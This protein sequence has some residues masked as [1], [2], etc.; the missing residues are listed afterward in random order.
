VRTL[1]I[2]S[3]GPVYFYAVHSADDAVREGYLESAFLPGKNFA[4]ELP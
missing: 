4:A 2:Q 3:V 1:D